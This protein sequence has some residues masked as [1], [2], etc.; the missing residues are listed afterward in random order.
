MSLKGVIDSYLVSLSKIG[1]DTSRYAKGL[2]GQART[3]IDSHCS[4][5]GPNLDNSELLIE[6]FDCIS[7]V[8]ENTKN[9]TLDQQVLLPGWIP[10]HPN[11]AVEEWQSISGYV[12]ASLF[13]IMHDSFG[14]YLCVDIGNDPEVSGRVC[15]CLQ[16]FLP[17][18]TF[19]SVSALFILHSEAVNRGIMYILRIDGRKELR[20]DYVKM[21]KLIDEYP[22]LAKNPP[23]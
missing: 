23:Q 14:N 5:R 16:G 18:P 6:Y 13:P 10:L 15:E 21:E 20:M 11:A 17:W 9:L 4:S 3:L 22:D 7:G 2:V 8:T 1:W 12:P 19:S